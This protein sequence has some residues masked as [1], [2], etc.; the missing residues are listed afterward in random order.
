MTSIK[1]KQSTTVIE[2]EALGPLSWTRFNKLAKAHGGNLT[3]LAREISS[4]V[5][6]TVAPGTVRKWKAKL[7]QKRSANS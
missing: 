7:L 4:Q 5:G 2:T 3:Q 6:Y 1:Q